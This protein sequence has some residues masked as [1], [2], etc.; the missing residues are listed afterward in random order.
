MK[1]NSASLLLIKEDGQS[2]ANKEKSVVVTLT[3]FL[4]VFITYSY[5]LHSSHHEPMCFS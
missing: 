3:L 2:K 1:Q 4:C 5:T